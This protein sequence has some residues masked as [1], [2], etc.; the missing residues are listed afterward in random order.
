MSQGKGEPRRETTCTP[1]LPLSPVQEA[2]PVTAQC[3]KSLYNKNYTRLVT[4]S[5]K[6]PERANLD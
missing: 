1:L 2:S 4:P 5:S 3:S 6:L